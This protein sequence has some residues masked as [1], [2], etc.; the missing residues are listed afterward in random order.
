MDNTLNWLYVHLANHCIIK[1]I[2]SELFAFV[3]LCMLSFLSMVCII[4]MLSFLRLLLMCYLLS[5]L[6]MFFGV[7][8]YYYFFILS[9]RK[10]WGFPRFAGDCASG[11]RKSQSGTALEQKSDIT[12]SCSQMMLQLHDIYDSN[13]VGCACYCHLIFL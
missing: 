4:C 8:L 7:M 11:H 5:C 6:R 2:A 13:K 3:G 9:G 10:L 1:D 12:D